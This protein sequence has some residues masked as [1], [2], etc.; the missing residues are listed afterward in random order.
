MV[1]EVLERALAFATDDPDCDIDD[2]IK[3]AV[4]DKLLPGRGV[5]RVVYEP[6][7]GSTTE[8]SAE[9]NDVGEVVV[10]EQEVEFVADQRLEFRYVY[11]KDFR[12]GQ[13]RR[14]KDM[15]WVAFRHELTEEELVGMGVDS[16][17]AE[18]VPKNA[19]PEDG[20]DEQKDEF[21]R[22]EV[23]EIW[24]KETRSRYWFVKSYPKLLKTDDDPYGLSQFFPIPKPLLAVTTT[25]SLVPVPEYHEYRDQASELDTVTS[26]LNKL[27]DAL[28]RRGV[29]NSEISGGV[30]SK[31]ASAADNQFI[32]VE[33]WSQLT[34]T[35]GLVGA[36][37][38]EDLA[39]IVQ[40][41]QSLYE[42]RAVLIQTIYEV[43]G[44]SDVIR[45]STDPRETAAA[46]KL[47]G[48]FGSMRIQEQQG[49]VAKFV[50]D[51]YRIA[52]ELIAEH[53]EPEILQRMTGKEV[54]PQMMQVM[55]DDKL[56]GFRVDIETD[57]TVFED[58]EAEKQSAVEL[59]TASTQFLGQATQLSSAVPEMTPLMFDMLS[60]AVRRFK[61][62][63]EIED[64]INQTRDQIMKKMQEQQQKPP[65]PDPKM[66][67]IKQK[68]Q[69]KQA[70]M[71][72][73]G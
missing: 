19:K 62:G 37:Q 13:A 48:Q 39:P 52:A 21:S 57:S 24:C 49:M 32:P 61:G 43:T 5:V 47:K 26:R 3:A 46:Q 45:G 67:E 30:L 69:L 18:S 16:D 29:Y 40:A 41:V 14:W 25:D 8:Q 7:I 53:Y 38:T 73:D 35:G 17:T 55:R 28:R 42:Q 64:T 44:I 36:F 60:M 56:R 50:R 22:A 31:L 66:E 4:S 59:M 9:I 15:P 58:A 6:I 10:T 63:R 23:W 65:P 20:D 72:Q 33:N 27:I 51:L 1:A 54:T 34:Q 70:E 11:W 68:G 12:H 71:Q 2:E